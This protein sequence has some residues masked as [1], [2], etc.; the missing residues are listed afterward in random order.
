[1]MVYSE[2]LG[3]DGRPK[4]ALVTPEGAQLLDDVGEGSLGE[5]FLVLS[6]FFLLLSL[7]RNQPSVVGR[8]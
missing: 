1:M 3:E 5:K 4:R 8:P 7:I 2:E 6:A